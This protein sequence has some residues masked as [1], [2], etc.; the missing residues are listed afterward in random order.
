[1]ETTNTTEQSLLERAQAALVAKPNLTKP[2]GKS[3]EAA[4]PIVA[5]ELLAQR[6]EI[7][8]AIKELTAQKNAIDAIIKDAIGKND[9]LTIHGAVVASISR[10]R[11][12][13]LNK[14]FIEENFPVVDFAEMY[15]RSD[16][17]RLNIKK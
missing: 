13:D 6:S 17:S 8:D 10:W 2:N 16:K 4:D 3:I 14:E 9:E 5:S 11:Q 12:T 15:V 1:M 7:A